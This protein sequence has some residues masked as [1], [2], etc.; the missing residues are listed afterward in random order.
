MQVLLVRRSD[1]RPTRIIGVV[2]QKC[3]TS[4]YHYT[5]VR[6]LWKDVAT[7]DSPYPQ[8][9]PMRQGNR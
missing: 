6:W 7:Y 8:R 5:E 1:F 2:G 9:S 4:G 3:R